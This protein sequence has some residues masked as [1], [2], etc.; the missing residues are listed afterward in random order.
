M[1]TVIKCDRCGKET[2]YAREIKLP[3][4]WYNKTDKDNGFDHKDVD[5]C[6]DCAES[7]KEWYA[8]CQPSK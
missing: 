2:D 8:I 6:H 4:W 5:L 3:L 7:L 1:A